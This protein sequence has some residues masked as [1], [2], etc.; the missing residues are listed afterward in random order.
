MIKK[1]VIDIPEEDHAEIKMISAHAGETMKKWVLRAIAERI[2]R[3]YEEKNS[4][5]GGRYYSP[6]E[7]PDKAPGFYE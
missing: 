4:K 3:D 7:S 6:G 1:L 2:R 5:I